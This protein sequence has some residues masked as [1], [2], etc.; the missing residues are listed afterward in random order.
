MVSLRAEVGAL[1]GDSDLVE[2][3]LEGGAGELALAR[4]PRAQWRGALRR[5]LREGR[6]LSQG[7]L[8]RAI[9]TILEAR[10][11]L[12]L[13]DSAL[14]DDP[15]HLVSRLEADFTLA[16]RGIERAVGES[17]AEAWDEFETAVGVGLTSP[18][19][20]MSLGATSFELSLGADA[21]KSGLMRQADRQERL[22]KGLALM[23]ENRHRVPEMSGRLGLVGGLLAAAVAIGGW[24]AFSGSLR[25]R[26]AELRR[27]LSNRSSDQRRAEVEQWVR[28]GFDEGVQRLT[29]EFDNQWRG[30]ETQL[31]EEYEQL[32]ASE[33][34]LLDVAASRV[35]AA[36][37][38]TAKPG[39][40][41]RVQSEVARVAELSSRTLELR[42]T[43][44]NDIAATL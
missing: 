42:S 38:A 31:T 13:E 10:R 30:I 36:A 6:E 41:E 17:A 25:D 14:L 24:L 29:L 5:V 32:L 19:S 33:A 11:D 22:T 16:L 7:G 15:D 4:S 2:K 40:L 34:S 8:D 9:T 35:R 12:Y 37:S 26:L 44:I 1:E 27:R 43:L 18:K 20:E 3:T 21:P 28:P 23:R 39:E